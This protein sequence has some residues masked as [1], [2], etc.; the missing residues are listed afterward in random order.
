MGCK[1]VEDISC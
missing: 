1:K